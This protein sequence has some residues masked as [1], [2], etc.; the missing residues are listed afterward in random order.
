MAGHL[1]TDLFLI[2]LAAVE[3]GKA[4]WVAMRRRRQ[5]ALVAQGQRATESRRP[6]RL[7]LVA[8]VEERTV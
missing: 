3:E 6:P 7:T 2:A 8:A 1:I 5:T 4:L